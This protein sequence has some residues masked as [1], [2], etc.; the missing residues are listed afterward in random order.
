MLRLPSQIKLRLSHSSKERR[1]LKHAISVELSV[2]KS[3]EIAQRMKTQNWSNQIDKQPKKL[4][5]LE[6]PIEAAEV[7]REVLIEVAVEA[8]EEAEEE[9][10]V[11]VIEV[12]VVKEEQEGVVVATEVEEEA[13]SSDQK[14]TTMMAT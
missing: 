1:D 7:V 12:E 5:K 13:K 14:D 4:E 2:A 11:E 10:A 3:L 8:K 6:V 9:A